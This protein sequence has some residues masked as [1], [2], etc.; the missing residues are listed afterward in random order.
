MSTDNLSRW[1]KLR[2]V[3]EVLLEPAFVESVSNGVG[4]EAYLDGLKENVSGRNARGDREEIHFDVNSNRVS[5]ILSV[6]SMNRSEAVKSGIL[7]LAD[8]AGEMIRD[9]V[10]GTDK[11]KFPQIK[12]IG[13]SG[14]E[15]LDY[16][17]EL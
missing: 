3:A 13:I 2:L 9:N 15:E 14:I 12:K 10:L 6:F 8:V 11:I 5:V 16:D 1:Y 4:L 7:R 17:G